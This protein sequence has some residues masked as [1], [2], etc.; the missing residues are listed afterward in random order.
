MKNSNEETFTRLVNDIE[1]TQEFANHFS[2]MILHELE[3]TMQTKSPVQRFRFINTTS[4]ETIYRLTTLISID[5]TT[6]T[7]FSKSGLKRS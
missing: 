4:A 5:S 7:K 3:Q 6:K 2:Q 1:E